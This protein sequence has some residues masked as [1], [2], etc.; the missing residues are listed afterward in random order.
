MN[1]QKEDAWREAKRRCRLNDEEV[2][3]AKALG[4]QPKSLIKNIPSPSQP[5]K[6]AVNEWVR[7]L[8]EKKTG[9]GKPLNTA[10][11]K[12][13][14]AL[15]L[16][17]QNGGERRNADDPWPD[18]P[19]IA[20]L[21]PLDLDADVAFDEVDFE[22]PSENDIDEQEGL[23]LRRQRL[24]RWAAQ[25]ISVAV[26]EI[27]EVEKVAAFGAVAQPLETE[28]P[29]FR[30]F[31]RHHIAILHECADLDLAIWMNDLSRLR[32]LKNAMARGLALV[33][34]TPYGGV[35]HHQ[36]DVHLFDSS[37]GQYRGRLCIFGKC[38]KPQKLQ[39]LVPGCGAQ[40]FL[41]QLD[42]YHFKSSFFAA[43]PKVI[44]F[45]RPTGFLARPPHIEGN[46]RQIKWTQPQY[47]G[48]TEQ[49]FTGDDLP[50]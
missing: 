6:A 39:C 43:A 20:D 25:A 12:A 34:N 11:P 37:T 28:V 17:P 21:P 7:S 49:D 1:R 36:V 24:F 5:W 33:Q 10:E 38:P 30:A 35:A 15:T 19:Q 45:E 32:D 3:M 42:N 27:A 31:R 4:F 40:P 2:R 23:M 9:S 22:P 14:P 29:R 47:D 26:S 8:Y 16:V 46:Q 50:F 13:Q 44:L 41:Q 18:H 48:G